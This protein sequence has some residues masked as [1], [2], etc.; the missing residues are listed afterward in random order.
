MNA[1]KGLSALTDT[2][3]NEIIKK[4][5]AIYSDNTQT[6]DNRLRIGE[7]LLQTVQRAGDALSIYGT[8][9]YS[10]WNEKDQGLMLC[11]SEKPC[12]TTRNGVESSSS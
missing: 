11:S 1:I 9:I 3:G 7:A 5:G 8:C 2:H 12:E 4:L 6:L 10:F